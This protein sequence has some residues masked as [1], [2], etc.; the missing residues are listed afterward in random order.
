M[1]T[2]NVAS[3]NTSPCQAIT[4]ILESMALQEAGLAHIINAEGDKL[5][6]AFQM[7]N[8]CVQDI[9]ALNSSITETLAKVFKLEMI[10]EYKLEEINKLQCIN[11]LSYP[12]ASNLP[13][14]CPPSCPPPGILP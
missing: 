6:E 14:S 11:C 10:L 7:R 13:S 3:T 12:N 8:V 5:Q 1:S 2:P 4:D 9:I